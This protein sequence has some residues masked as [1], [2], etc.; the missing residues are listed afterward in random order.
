MTKITKTNQSHKSYR[1]YKSEN[2]RTR[3]SEYIRGRIRCHGVVSIPCRPVAPAVRPIVYHI[4]NHIIEETFDV[5]WN[6][7]ILLYIYKDSRYI[8]LFTQNPAIQPDSRIYSAEV[9]SKVLTHSCKCIIYFWFFY[10]LTSRLRFLFSITSP[11]L[12]GGCKI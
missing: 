1:K 2:G 12:V 9:G 6:P 10:C 8:L 3:T 11:L 5:V 7:H 4:S